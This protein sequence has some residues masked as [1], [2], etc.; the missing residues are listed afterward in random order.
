MSATMDLVRDILDSQ[1]V[2]RNG[3]NIGRV[4]GILLELRHTRPPRVAALEVGA[5]TLARRI[6]PRLARWFRAVMAKVAPVR[7]TP[8]R[9]PPHAFRDIGADIELDVDADTK[10]LRIENWVR[11][12]IVARLPGGGA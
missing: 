1:L 9:I 5:V 6:H 11:R 7:V 12:H 8:V 3:R 10:L 4:D 2:D